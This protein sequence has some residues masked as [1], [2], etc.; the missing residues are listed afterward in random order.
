M[1]NFAVMYKNLCHSSLPFSS[2]GHEQCLIDEFNYAKLHP[3]IQHC[4]NV[5]KPNRKCLYF[6][7]FSS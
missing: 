6:C 2:N 4:S 3:G 5:T 7:L 1:S